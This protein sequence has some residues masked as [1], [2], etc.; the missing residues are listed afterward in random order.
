MYVDDALAGNY[1]QQSASRV[2]AF[3]CAS[4]LEMRGN[5]Y[6]VFQNNT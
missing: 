3:R 4:G 1:T 6:K 2:Q 5:Y